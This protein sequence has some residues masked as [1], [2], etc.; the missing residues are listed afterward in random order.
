[1][2]RIMV[3][4]LSML[5]AGSVIAAQAQQGTATSTTTTTKTP[6]KKV[7]AKKTGPTVSEQLSEMKEAIDAQQRQIK[8]LSDSGSEPRSKD[9]ATRTTP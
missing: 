2:K 5:V 7:A 9:S 1:M 6:R 3:V 4:V 8:Q